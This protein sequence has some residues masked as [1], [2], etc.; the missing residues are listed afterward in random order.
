MLYLHIKDYEL[1]YNAN[2]EVEKLEKTKA[3]IEKIKSKFPAGINNAPIQEILEALG[4]T[5]KKDSD[6]LLIISHYGDT[7]LDYS[8]SD[9]GIDEDRLFKDIKA[10][11]EYAVFGTSKVTNL[12]NLQSIGGNADFTDSQ[13]TNLGNLQYIGGYADFKYSEVTDLGNLQT[14]GGYASFE[15]SQITDLGNLQSIGDSAWFERSRITSL[16]NLQTIGGDVYI[17][18]SKLKPSDFNSIGVKGKIYQ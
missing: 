10:I 14:I 7:E 2:R 1:S 5:C 13:L 11:E 12:G 4:I 3:E 8:Y 16:G 18:N 15:D 17:R 6:G 9:L